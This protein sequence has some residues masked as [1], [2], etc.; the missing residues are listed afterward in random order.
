MSIHLSNDVA[1]TR[2]DDL[3]RTARRHEAV[4]VAAVAVRPATLADTTAVIRL[5]ALDSAPVPAGT[6]LI[7]EVGGEVQA[8]IA[9]ETG[10][11]VADPFRRTATAVRVLRAH[12]AQGRRDARRSRAPRYRRVLARGAA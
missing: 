8:A 9:V 7:A 5:A 1:R 3:H 12:A 11:V 6:V 10:A 4:D 2:I